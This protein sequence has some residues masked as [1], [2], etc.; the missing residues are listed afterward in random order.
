MVFCAKCGNEETPD[1]NFCSKCGSA[2]ASSS[3]E[4]S[5]SY[6]ARKSRWWYLLP[7]FFSVIGG[8][9]AYLILKDDDKPLA[10]NCL[11]L[12]IILTVVGF[13]LGLGFGMMSAF[14]HY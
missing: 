13:V 3:Q 1:K 8:I 9:I 5:G 2:L 7:I 10:K 11:Y 12:G 14:M 6:K 4:Y